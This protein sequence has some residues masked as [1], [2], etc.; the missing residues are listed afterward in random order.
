MGVELRADVSHVYHLK[1]AHELDQFELKI[2]SIGYELDA[3]I[4]CLAVVAGNV[5]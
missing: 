5:D 4:L 3:A 1:I 2:L